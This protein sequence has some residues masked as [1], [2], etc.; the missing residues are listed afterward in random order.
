MGQLGWLW[1]LLPVPIPVERLHF[2]VKFITH[3]PSL[4]AS[5]AGES[6]GDAKEEEEV[7]S[8]MLIEL[9]AKEASISS[10]SGTSPCFLSL[11]FSRDYLGKGENQIIKP[12]DLIH[13]ASHWALGISKLPSAG[14]SP[15]LY[16]IQMAH[17]DLYLA[18][19]WESLLFFFK[20]YFGFQR[21]NV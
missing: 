14:A 21:C 8:N 13:M 19:T 20:N 3:L 6:T 17:F 11:S 15:Y 12:L 7:S 1:L 2:Q 4:G 16:H 9:Q 18:S 10:P 5:S